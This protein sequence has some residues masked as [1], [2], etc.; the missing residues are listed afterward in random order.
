[1][2]IIQAGLQNYQPDYLNQ[3][4]SGDLRMSDW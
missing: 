2:T 3:I 4:L 1:V